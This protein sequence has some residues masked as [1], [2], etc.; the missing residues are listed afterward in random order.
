MPQEVGK[1]VITNYTCGKLLG[2]G[3][4][5]FTNHLLTSWDIQVGPYDHYNMELRVPVNGLK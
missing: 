3:F 5:P 2:F 4:N 1:R